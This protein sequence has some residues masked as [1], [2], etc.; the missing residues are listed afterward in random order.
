MSTIQSAQ[1]AAYSRVLA[2]WRAAVQTQAAKGVKR[3]VAIAIVANQNPN[4]VNRLDQ[5]WA[6]VETSQR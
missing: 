4:I 3:H 1:Q 2:E 6:N 5:A